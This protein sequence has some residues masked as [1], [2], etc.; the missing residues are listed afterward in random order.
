MTHPCVKKSLHVPVRLWLRTNK[1]L[2][3]NALGVS[4]A[5]LLRARLR[6]IFETEPR[7]EGADESCLDRTANG[8]VDNWRGELGS[9]NAM[10][11]GG[12]VPTLFT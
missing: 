12:F 2:F 9:P 11:R 6:S 3:M 5:R 4:A 1:S 8:G 7:P 10:S